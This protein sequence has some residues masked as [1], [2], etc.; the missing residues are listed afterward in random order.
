MSSFRE[1]RDE[2]RG[3]G[4]NGEPV[5]YVCETLP[6]LSEAM[7]GVFD[8]GQRVW[9]MQPHTLSLWLDGR[10]TKFCLS[11]GE[12]WPKF[13]SSFEGL[14]AAV[15]SVEECLRLRRGDWRQPRARLNR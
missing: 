9:V 15:E 10:L 8:Q 1:F 3:K 14:D 12:H 2:Y 7:S 11:A 4:S 5:P 6:L 13:F